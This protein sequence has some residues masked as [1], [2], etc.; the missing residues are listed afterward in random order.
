MKV[1]GERKPISISISCALG[2]QAGIRID[3][4]TTATHCA[5]QFGKKEGKIMPGESNSFRSKGIQETRSRAV[6]GVSPKVKINLKR[7][8]YLYVPMI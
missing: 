3:S 1:N 7:D 5:P 4:S 2:F 8:V 6:K